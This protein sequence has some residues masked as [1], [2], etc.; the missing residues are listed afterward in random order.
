M[1]DISAGTH[2]VGHKSLAFIVPITPVIIQ[3]S[4]ISFISIIS[5]AIDN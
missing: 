3:Y 4:F 5:M 1:K 2:T